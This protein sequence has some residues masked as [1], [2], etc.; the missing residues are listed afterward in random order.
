MACGESTSSIQQAGANSVCTDAGVC[1]LTCRNDADCPAQLDVAQMA[2]ATAP[3]FAL[4]RT[5]IALALRKVALPS[6]AR[7]RIARMHR[8]AL[9]FSSFFWRLRSAPGMKFAS[10]GRQRSSMALASTVRRPR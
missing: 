3:W 6:I 9:D 8:A 2:I 4:R 1:V 10:H 5:R 7:A